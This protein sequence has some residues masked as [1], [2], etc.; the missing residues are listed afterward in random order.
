M[1]RRGSAPSWRKQPLR[2]ASEKG[3]FRNQNPPQVTA[4]M[5]C[6]RERRSAV[7]AADLDV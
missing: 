3:D 1:Q 5:D 4:L 6:V 2:F 7:K